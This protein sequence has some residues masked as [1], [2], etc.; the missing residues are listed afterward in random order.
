M[1]IVRSMLPVGVGMLEVFAG[2]ARLTAAVDALGL[3]VAVPLEIRVGPEFN[4][5]NSEVFAVVRKWI[6][7]H[8][9]WYVH[10]AVPCRFWS[11]ATC[12][13]ARPRYQR[14]GLQLARRTLALIRLCQLHSVHWSLENQLSSRLFL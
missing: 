11:A 9:V 13:S 1:R 4:I 14:E 10:F 2:T 12:E 8:K 5:L 3:S 7:S 6:V